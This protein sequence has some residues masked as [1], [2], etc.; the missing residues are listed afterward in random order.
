MVHTRS[1]RLLAAVSVLALAGPAGAQV[2]S[3]CLVGKNK[4]VTSNASALLKCEQLAET[5]GKTADPN[6]GG[7]VD[8]AQEKFDGGATPAKGC[9]EKLEGKVPKDCVTFDD[10]AAAAAAVDACVASIVAAI[11]PPPLTQSKCNV[12]KKKCATKKLASVLKCYQKAQTPGKSTDPDAL[13]CITKAQEKFDGGVDP[14][15]GCIAKLEAKV[16]NDCVAPLGNTAAIEAVVDQCVTDL[17]TL[18]TTATTTTTTSTTSTTSTTTTTTVPGVV[19]FSASVQPIFNNN[20]TGCHSGPSPS[21][22]LNLSAASS[23]ANLVNV[24]SVECTSTERVA[25]G[26]S[27]ASYL[28]HK[29]LGTGPCYFG[30]RMPFGGQPLTAGEM[31][32]ITDWI[33]QGA[34]NH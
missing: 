30:V 23:Y 16:G 32:I 6:A 33:D 29:L 21:S 34:A 9:F 5:P 14:S 4:C 22:S 13:G 26:D 24:L 25:P 2:Q 1:L 11:D 15:K 31:Q 28:V 12:G 7:C 3:K 18:L 8:K 17:V 19:S 10:T 20:C 27:G